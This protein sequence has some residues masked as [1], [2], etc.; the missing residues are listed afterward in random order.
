[1]KKTSWA[2]DIFSEIDTEKG[3]RSSH[4]RQA[5]QSSAFSLMH[6]NGL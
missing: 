1:M 6:C 4:E 3:Q 2:F 5:I